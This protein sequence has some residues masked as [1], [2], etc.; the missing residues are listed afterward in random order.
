MSLGEGFV[1]SLLP[2]VR[3]DPAR[4]LVRLWLHLQ[5]HVNLE[6]GLDRKRCEDEATRLR[7]R[8]ESEGPLQA[9]HPAAALR[10]VDRFLAEAVDLGHEPR[11][12]RIRLEDEEGAG[13]YWVVPRRSGWSSRL[14][15]TQPGHLEYWM[16]GYQVI[17]TQH[18]GIEIRVRRVVQEVWDALDSDETAFAAGGFT[19]GVLPAWNRRSPYRCRRLADSAQRWGSVESFLK[20]A[21]ERGA[22]LAVLPELTV[23]PEVRQ[24]L[25]AWLRERTAHR[26]VLIAAGSFHE[27]W[28]EKG[29]K[30][31]RG[32]A[33][34]FDRWGDEVLT[35]AKLRPM[36]AMPKGRVADEALEAGTSVDLLL[37]PFGLLGLAI[38]L[39]YCEIGAPCVTRGASHGRALRRPTSPPRRA[40][41][42]TGMNFP[43]SFLE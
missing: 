18:R 40:P 42:D 2:S 39:D 21:G 8:L 27:A 31:A 29:A 26:F 1:A 37:A 34:V 15:E 24:R 30:T 7:R 16:R 43:V 36:R 6:R 19:D 5:D 28:P 25:R 9:V 3:A 13:S 23:D 33:R 32:I 20:K 12:R 22:V 38:C 17:P 14:S 4:A 41:L 35:H 11:V 10:A